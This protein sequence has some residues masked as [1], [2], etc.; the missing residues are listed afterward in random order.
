MVAKIFSYFRP[1]PNYYTRAG[2]KRRVLLKII[3][4]GDAAVGKTSCISRYVDNKFPTTGYKPTIGA[5]FLS[6]HRTVGDQEVGL[7]IWDTAGQE[8]FNALGASFYRGSDAVIIVFD[9]TSK[10]SF[11]SVQ[12]WNDLCRATVGDNV[13]IFVFGNKLD[14]DAK[15]VVSSK[16]AREYC[17]KLFYH[18]WEVSGLTGANLGIAMSDVVSQTLSGMGGGGLTCA[19]P[20]CMV[21]DPL[22]EEEGY[23]SSC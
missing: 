23:C 1:P 11:D 4:L 6:T 14:L 3:L 13:P 20:M 17:S 10:S 15:R 7:Q 21:L 22:P 16:T 18:Y 2:G 5:D 19:L 12:M 8:R 9:I